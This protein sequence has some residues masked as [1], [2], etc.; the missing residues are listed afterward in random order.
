[1]CGGALITIYVIQ[2]IFITLVLGKSF[3]VDDMLLCKQRIE[4]KHSNFPQHRKF[5]ATASPISINSKI[6]LNDGNQAP[7]IGIGYDMRN[8]TTF[9]SQGVCN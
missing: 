6:T 3:K 4:L 1:M 5:S 8:I 7:I 2:R 9:I